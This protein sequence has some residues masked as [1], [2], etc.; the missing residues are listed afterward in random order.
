MLQ[1]GVF[2]RNEDNVSDFALIHMSNSAKEVTFF[3]MFVC[4]KERKEIGS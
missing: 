2:N 4:Q 1:F 3:L